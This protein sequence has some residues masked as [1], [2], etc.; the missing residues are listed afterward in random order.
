[1]VAQRD[2]FLASLVLFASLRLCASALNAM[3]FRNSI[4]RMRNI[5]YIIDL[6]IV[7]V[8]SVG[9]RVGGAGQNGRS[10]GWLQG[11][12]RI[13]CPP[14]VHLCCFAALPPPS[15]PSLRR[16]GG[17]IDA[18]PGLPSL[19]RTW[20]PGAARET[21]CRQNHHG[22]RGDT[23]AGALAPRGRASGLAIR[24]RSREVLSRAATPPAFASA[25]SQPN[26]G[27]PSPPATLMVQA[28]GQER[29]Q[30][31]PSCRGCR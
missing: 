5:W 2:P 16:H 8:S 21:T 13:A 12:A 18:K 22:R 27:P 25:R 20:P 28:R 31:S 14:E 7:R 3:P 10:P 24:S 19:F 4:D 26:R 17:G 9:C 6:G 30:P 29:I 11:A 1:M 23:A 15:A